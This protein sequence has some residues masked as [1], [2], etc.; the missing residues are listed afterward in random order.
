MSQNF[1]K[2]LYPGIKVKRWVFSLLFGV[3]IVGVGSAFASSPYAFV[4]AMGVVMILCGIMFIVLSIG[5][6]IISLLT[7]FLPQRE[8]DIVDILYQ[9]RYLERGPK[10]VAI[11][12]GH[13]LSHLLLGLKEYTANL[14]AIVTV[15]D[16]GGSS[17]LLRQQFNIVAPGDIRN[18]LVALA[19]TPALMGELFQYRFE[20]GAGL[21]GHSFG[22]LFLTAMVQITNG[23]FKRAVEE[24]SKVLAVRGKVIPSTVHNVHL[25]AEYMDGSITKGEAK[26]PQV[27]AVIKRLFLTPDD[28]KPTDDAL[29]AIDQADI[30]VMGPGSLYTSIL[31][32]LIIRGM[33]E[34]LAAS[35]AYKI[36]VCNVMTQQ[37]ETDN[38]SASDHLRV[39]LEHSNPKIVDACLINDAV[40]SNEEA[41]NRY[42]QENAY[43][44]A[45]DSERIK[46]MGIKVVATDLL[47]VA[48]YVRHDSK[49]LTQ[50][51]IRL[52]E[53]QRVIKR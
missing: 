43:P 20:E 26:I 1:F 36:Y 19:D 49:K 40:V 41:L 35:K 5:K 22:N 27:N 34:A 30:I 17:G 29:T 21:K 33:G 28:A 13:G 51:L 38:F 9:R 16:S 53:T 48:D 39:L 6:L 50:A 3:I 25:V 10:V 42:R 46:A 2:W 14:T 37:G 45:A 7:L 47:S 32:N 23:D 31:P 18:C 24:S 12:G 8:R 15:A 11:G 4:S 52:I 44:V